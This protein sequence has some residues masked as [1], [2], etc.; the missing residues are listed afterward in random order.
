MRAQ[1]ASV[2]QRRRAFAER[3][4]RRARKYLFV[5]PHRMRATLERAGGQRLTRA[6]KI[7][8]SQEGT[9][10]H[11]AEIVAEAVV[12]HITALAPGTLESRE[13]RWHGAASLAPTLNFDL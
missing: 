7:V 11:R 3:D 4:R 12:A 5:A 2:N 8:A 10:A 1:P 9:L 13:S 6:G